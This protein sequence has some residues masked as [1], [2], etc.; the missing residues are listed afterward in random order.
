LRN[1]KILL[2]LTASKRRNRR[3]GSLIELV[4]IAPWIFFLFIGALDWGFYA[5]A[6]VSLQSGLRSAA[7]YTATSPAT[8]DDQASACTLILAEMQKLPNIGTGVTTCGASPVVV[9]AV[10]LNGPDGAVATKVTLTYNSI[11]LIPIPGL[12]AKQFAVTR[13]V[14]MRVRSST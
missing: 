11:S 1:P 3:G 5:S 2:P 14:T 7:L 9:T 13:D 6:L 8:A 12:L 10:K 4:L